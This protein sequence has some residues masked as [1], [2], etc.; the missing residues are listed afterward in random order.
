MKDLEIAATV[1]H[2]VRLFLRS[3]VERSRPADRRDAAGRAG[4]GGMRLFRERAAQRAEEGM[5]LHLLLRSH[6]LGMY[7]L[8]QGLRE[9]A[10]PGEEAALGELADLLP[11]SHHGIVGAVAE[12]CLDERSAIDAER[13]AHRRSLVRGLLDGTLPPGHVL[14]EQLGLDGPCLVLAVGTATGPVP[15]ATAPSGEEGAVAVR[16]RL[17]RIQTALDH[18]FG[19]EVPSLLDAGCDGGRAIVPEAAEPPDPPSRRHRVHGPFSTAAAGKE[20]PARETGLPVGGDLR[21]RVVSGSPGSRP[22]SHTCAYSSSPFHRQPVRPGSTTK[23]TVGPRVPNP[24]VVRRVGCSKSTYQFRRP[25]LVRKALALRRPP[26]ASAAAARSPATPR[27][28]PPARRSSS[29][30]ALT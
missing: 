29:V 14:L 2:G 3:V 22:R 15:A 11:G 27:P 30:R 17:R 18:A 23:P 8:W 1:R 19:V 26:A 12:T 28:R 16:R 4:K 7:V 25:V 10:A 5:P 24:F 21:K 6:A 9:S 13:R 20:V